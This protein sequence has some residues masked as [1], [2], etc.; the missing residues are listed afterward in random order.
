MVGDTE[1]TG[2]ESD[3]ALVESTRKAGNVVHV[4]GGRQRRADRS[5]EGG[6]RG[7]QRAGAQSSTL[8]AAGAS[9]RARAVTPP[10][11]ALAAGR[12]APSATRCSS[13]TP[14]VRCAG[15][16]RSCRSATAPFPSL[17]L[18]ATTGA[19]VPTA[20]SAR[21]G[22][23]PRA[24]RG[25]GAVA[26]AGAEP[27]RPSDVHVV[28]V[29]RPVLRRS[30]RSRG[31]EARG[32]SGAV[33]RSHRD[34]R[35]HRRRAERRVHHAVSRRR[36][37]RAGSPRQR[38]RRRC[39]RTARSCRSPAGSPWR[40]TVA[41]AARRRRGRLV[42]QG[43]ADRRGGAAAAAAL[44]VWQSVA[45]FARGLWIPVTVPTLA[46]VFAFV[47]DLAWK[48]FVEGR[49]KRQGQAAV[50]ALRVE[51]RLRPAAR[52]P[53]ARRAGRRAAAHD[54]ALLRRARLHD[55]VGEGHARR[56]RRPAERVLH[57][58]GRRAVRAPRHARQVRRRHGDG[59]LRRA[60]RRRGPRRA[61]G[62]DRAGDD[63]RRSTSSIA[64]GRARAG[65]RSTSA[66]ASTPATWWPATSG[67]IRS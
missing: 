19:R 18:A 53:V 54:R 22:V 66:S 9:K 57:A 31:P 29:L 28:L 2:E 63:P 49:E 36:D 30:S 67:P 16:R 27:G 39:W 64:N 26:R 23:R 44:L 17:P 37:P 43:V 65:R 3:A 13:T 11:P 5:V 41:G 59:A 51:G 48:Y 62:A 40:S 21:V 58:H 33:Q 56:R 4:G 42:P 15:S 34:R 6:R 52:R 12:R 1:W 60:A 47:G 32:R 24:V 14:T 10:F 38:D 20:H 45:L 7:P 50:L 25:A 35:R 46:I 55:D 8:A 61:R